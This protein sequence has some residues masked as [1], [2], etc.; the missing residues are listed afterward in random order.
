MNGLKDYGSFLEHLKSGD[1]LRTI[2]DRE[3]PQ[4]RTVSLNGQDLLNFSSNDYLGLAANDAVVK[5]AAASLTKYGF[6]GGASRLLSG[7]TS[8]HAML[9]AKLAAFK[10]TEKSILFNS[11]YAANSGAIPA[12]T[13][14]DDTA[15]FSDELNH[16]SIIDGCKLAKASTST[17]TSTH[18]YEHGDID[19]LR[20]L[21][22]HSSTAHKIVVTES[23]FS[24]DGRLVNLRGIYELCRE[25][26]ALL[27]VDDAHALGTIG[28]GH[29]GLRHFGIEPDEDV[30]QMGTLS[31]AL[32]SVGGFIAASKTI[33]DFLVNTSR[34]LIF[35]TA[36][37]SSAVCAALAA[38][39]YLENHG[40]L[41]TR[42]NENVTMAG[43][44]FKRYGVTINN[45]CTPI[46][47]VLFEDSG[48]ALAASK[49]LLDNG[50]YAPAIRPP[51]VKQPRVRIT[52]TAL[53][54]AEDIEYLAKTLSEITR[55]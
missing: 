52:I 5:A 17:S 20:K 37:P 51:T 25:Y 53:H 13:S 28:G 54:T 39:E 26:G 12:L 33:V 44:L 46:V 34:S 6:G 32:G 18:V 43:N 27:Y 41:V 8:A 35:S 42:L 21:L 7:G 49:S 15:I 38:I 23:V 31:K 2:R 36:L 29:G 10:G 14:L 24:M 30:I 50:I 4:G 45:I 40:E 47:P 1:L 55:R 16:A 48:A 9:E 22:S 19:H 3:S 11:G